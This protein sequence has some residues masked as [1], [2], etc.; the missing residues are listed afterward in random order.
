MQSESLTK[1]KENGS[2]IKEIG[3]W[4][5]ENEENVFTKLIKMKF[6]D[7]WEITNRKFKS[8]RREHAKQQ[9]EHGETERVDKLERLRNVPEPL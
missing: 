9:N 7:N 5:R 2:Q 6:N 1:H 3:R 4:S 8:V